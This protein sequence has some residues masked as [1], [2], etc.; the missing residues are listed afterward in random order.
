[1]HE[2]LKQSHEK[3]ISENNDVIASSKSSQDEIDSALT[4]ISKTKEIMKKEKEIIQLLKEKGYK[5]CYVEM[6]EKNIK[7]VVNLK[8][9]SSQDANKIIKAIR[10]YLNHIYDIEVKFVTE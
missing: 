4:S 2:E 5:E 10:E 9:G 6:T 3:R 8:N 7:V 1:M